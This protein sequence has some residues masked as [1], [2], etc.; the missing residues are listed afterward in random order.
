MENFLAKG[1]LVDFVISKSK[2]LEAMGV[3]VT[4]L[5]VD[6]DKNQ[7]LEIYGEHFG[8]IIKDQAKTIHETMEENRDFLV[9]NKNI[10]ENGPSPLPHRDEEPTDGSLQSEPLLRVAQG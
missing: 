3:A 9:Y 7:I 8:D 10:N 1:D 5:G 4:Y 6:N 2:Q